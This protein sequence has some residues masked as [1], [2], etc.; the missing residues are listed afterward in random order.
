MARHMGIMTSD[1]LGVSASTNRA[2]RARRHPLQA[3]ILALGL[4][5]VAA[6]PINASTF[7][8]SDNVTSTAAAEMGRGTAVTNIVNRR[9]DAGEDG[10]ALTYWT[11]ERM[12]DSLPASFHARGRGDA[13][14]SPDHGQPVDLPASKPVADAKESAPDAA[15]SAQTLSTSATLSTTATSTSTS[16][17]YWQGS[18]TANPNAQIGRLFFQ[19]WDS[20]T[21]TWQDYNCSA[22]VVS[23]ENKSVLWTAGHCVFE[24][25]SNTWNRYYAFCPGYRNHTCPLGSWT[26]YSQSTTSAWQNSVCSTDHRCT[27]SEFL[28]DF[29]A[30]K[31]N[32]INGYTIASWVGSNGIAFNG[33]IYQSRYLFGYPLNKT[34]GEYLYY[35]SGDNTVVGGNLRLAPCG[36]GG[37]ASGGPWLSQ[38]NSSWQGVV[39]SVNS[40]GDGTYMAGPYQ[41]TVAQDLFS[42]VRY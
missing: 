6:A 20:I 21:R 36:A 40:H 37:G 27:E 30:L 31:M 10:R 32:A 3:T 1:T 25:N 26:P 4:V 35:C 7:P 42:N 17:G 34:S 28:Y 22:S 18:N 38:I 8:S 41:G 12:R 11:K 5:L 16:E 13:V 9:I 15:S 14:T 33:A 23:S 29:G 39:H 24:T 2:T 19:Q